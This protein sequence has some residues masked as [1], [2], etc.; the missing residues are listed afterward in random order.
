MSNERLNN[1][2]LITGAA[3]RVG[4]HLAR[5]FLQ[6]TDYPVIFTYRTHRQAVDELIA[7]GAIAVQCD[8]QNDFELPGLVMTVQHHVASLRAIIHNASVWLNDEQAPPMSEGFKQLFRVHVEAP[9]YLNEQLQGLLMASDSELKDIISLSD[10]SVNRVSTT[11]SAYLASKAAL[12]TLS[13]SYAKKFAPDIKVN[14][15]APALI[16]FNDGDSDE[17]KRQRLAKAAIPI[18]PGFDVVWQAVN[19]LLQ[20]PYTTGITLPLN[21]GR[22]LI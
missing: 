10:Y 14:D 17:Y 2:I 6:H 18:E 16:E 13:Q 11:H 3:Q 9:S 1:A 12:Q 5:Q 4:E 15:I 7:L 19:Y 22:H 8:F 21:G 20:S